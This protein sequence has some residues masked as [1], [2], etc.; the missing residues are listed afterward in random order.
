MNSLNVRT[1][2]FATQS[3]RVMPLLLLTLTLAAIGMP[4][5]YG[6]SDPNS[7]DE[8]LPA[9]LPV[10]E[11]F[12]PNHPTGEV[13]ISPS[14]SNPLI[15]ISSTSNTAGIGSATLSLSQGE[16]PESIAV[17]LYLRGLEGFTATNGTTTIDRH[18]LNVQAFD[19]NMMPSDQKYLMEDAGY[20]EVRLPRSLFTEDTTEIRIQWVDFYRQ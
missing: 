9:P 16:W 5:A 13:T 2:S 19:R 20:Y 3:F 14:E 17:R 6:C 1:K 7:L 4:D 12:Y 10:L 11:I 18:Q 8:S 15:N